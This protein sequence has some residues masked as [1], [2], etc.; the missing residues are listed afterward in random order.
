MS[1]GGVSA[2]A[3]ALN[4][5][6]PA[7]SKQIAVLEETLGIRLFARRRGGPFVPTKEGIAFFKSIEG[8][9][10]GL[11]AIPD[12]AQG[13]AQQVRTQLRIAATPPI[14]N[15]NAFMRALA[16]FRARSPGVQV[17]IVARQRVDLED[18]VR[19]RQ[20]DLGLGLLPSRYP[21]LA[22]ITL[23]DRH[24]VAV[25][26]PNHHLAARTTIVTGDLKASALILPSRQPLRDRIDAALPGLTCDIETSSSISCVGLALSQT[27]MALCD[28][29]SPSMY[30]DTMVRVLPFEPAIP[31]S[32]GAL[33]SRETEAEP[34]IAAF[35]E[36]LKENFGT[37]ETY[38]P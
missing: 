24:C 15:S 4:L 20:A 14:I 16:G 37:S 25:M 8:T 29:F 30:P 6:Q 36:E 7:L 38:T 31:L 22:S 10:Y 19:N 1:L 32:Y 2:A 17:S 27:A 12:I 33:L 13:I 28:P 18:W 21:D 9:L 26:S 5:T 34:L 11:D 3:E 35:L 23:A